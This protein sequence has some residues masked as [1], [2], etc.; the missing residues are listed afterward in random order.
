M[1]ARKRE[2]MPN[3]IFFMPNR[4]PDHLIFATWNLQ[5]FK[6]DCFLLN[7]ERPSLLNR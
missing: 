2:V 6:N 1:S 3:V 5:V 4:L 7:G